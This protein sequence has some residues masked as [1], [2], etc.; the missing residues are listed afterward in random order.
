MFG[1]ENLEFVGHVVGVDGL[2]PC[3][4]KVSKIQQASIPKQKKELRSFLGLVGYYRKFIP[5][6]AEKA[7]ALTELTRKGQPN[8]LVFTEAQFNAFM[9]LKNALINPPVLRLP[10]VNRMFILRTDASNSALGAV[11]LQEY[12]GIF[13]PVCYISRRLLPREEHYSV[14][15]RECLAVHKFQIYL[16]GIEFILQVDHQPLIYLQKNKVTNSRL[17]RWA[18]QL[19]TF[20]FTIEAIK[21]KE[22]VGADYMS[23]ISS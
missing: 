22:N 13:F 8:T 3:Q 5:N 20:Q 19:Q 10:D 23:R 14:I 17:M 18:M 21:G 16:Y 6:F 9:E 4:D 2:S 11:L 7:S 12:S 1:F 15:E